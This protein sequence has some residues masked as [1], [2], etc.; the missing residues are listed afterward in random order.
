MARP[1]LRVAVVG[2]GLGGH[3]YD[4]FP[5]ADGTT[6]MASGYDTPERFE[7]ELRAGRYAPRPTGHSYGESQGSDFEGALVVDKRAPLRERPSLSYLAPLCEPGLEGDAVSPPPTPSA[8]LVTGLQGAF[9]TLV[10]L[11]QRPGFLGLTKVSPTVYVAWWRRHG[12]RTGVIRDGAIVW[13]P[14]PSIAPTEPS[15]EPMQA[16]LGF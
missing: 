4:C 16:S 13:A 10:K 1:P 15:P 14:A 12:A 6:V 8:T 3:T 2:F 7:A 11:Q 5:E 9:A